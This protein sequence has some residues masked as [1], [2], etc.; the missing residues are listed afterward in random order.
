MH[1]LPSLAQ[2]ALLTLQEYTGLLSFGW[3]VA[4]QIGDNEA[5]DPIFL[6]VCFF[7]H[8]PLLYSEFLTDF[9]FCLLEEVLFLLD[10]VPKK[11]GE[12]TL[13]PTI[14][15]QRDS[16]ILLIM[17]HPS[18]V[19]AACCCLLYECRGGTRELWR[20]SYCCLH[21]QSSTALRKV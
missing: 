14:R 18:G 20:Q 19:T 6:F 7:F 1:F 4:L 16:E 3:D 17:S 5:S 13:Y 12:Q 2:S 9:R 21:E 8:L 15:L 10:S 11:K